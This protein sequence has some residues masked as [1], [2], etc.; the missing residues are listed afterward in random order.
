MYIRVWIRD[1][2]VAVGG[3]MVKLDIYTL[4]RRTGTFGRDTNTWKL[5]MHTSTGRILALD[6]RARHM[7]GFDCLQL[8][9]QRG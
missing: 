5:Y 4:A 3:G 1:C 8:Q 9:K 6:G 7:D 2:G